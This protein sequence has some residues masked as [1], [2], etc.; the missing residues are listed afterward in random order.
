M[1]RFNEPAIEPHVELLRPPHA[2]EVVLI[3]PL[4]TNLDQVLAVD[5]EVVRDGHAAARS[6]RQVFAL[7][8]VL[9]DMQRNLEASDSPGLAGGRPIASRVTCRATDR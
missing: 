9:H 2:Y 3:L 4:Q 6:E 5:R 1:K 8:I 7:P